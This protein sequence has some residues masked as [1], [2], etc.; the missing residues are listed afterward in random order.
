MLDSSKAGVDESTNI[1]LMPLLQT[2]AHCAI[3]IIS[4][5]YILKCNRA[6]RAVVGGR[7]RLISI[8]VYLLAPQ[9]A[10]IFRIGIV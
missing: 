10:R 5:A 3:P 2:T 4:V 6:G 1:E 7:A 9:A 8:T